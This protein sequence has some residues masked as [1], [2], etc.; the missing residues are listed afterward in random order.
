M[1]QI[2]VSP[3]YGPVV[4]CAISDSYFGCRYEATNPFGETL[5]VGCFV[6]KPAGVFQGDPD[7]VS[8]A[9]LKLGGPYG[10]TPISEH[11]PDIFVDFA[12]KY[13]NPITYTVT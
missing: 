1:G 11:D 2:T 8:Q 12:E 10:R 7:D 4:C 3:D 9:I 13:K 5:W 6:D